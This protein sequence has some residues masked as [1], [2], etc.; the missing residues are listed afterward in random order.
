[1]RFIKWQVV[2]AVTLLL[3]TV[4]ISANNP[5]YI[6]GEV[7]Y[8]QDFAV[9]SDF[10]LSGIQKGTASSELSAFSCR[11]GAFRIETF[12]DGRVYAILPSSNRTTDFTLEFDF[13]FTKTANS[14]GYLAAILTST[15]EEPGNISQVTIRAKGTI[16][17]FE[18]P[19]PELAEHIR[20][21]ET[22]SVK[23][24]VENGVVKTLFLSADGV[25]EEIQRTSLMLIG[26]GNRGFSV[27]NA[28]VDIREVFIVNGTD[29]EN[30]VGYWAE[31]SYADDSASSG[32]VTPTGPDS[33]N[34]ETAPETEDHFPI[35]VL[36]ISA[37][38]FAAVRRLKK[39]KK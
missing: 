31:H 38:S 15:G 16:D 33:N 7:L 39:C 18:A 36:L 28:D 5:V 8:H 9:L 3:L 23:I 35:A 24:P 6:Q 10:S 2:F 1:M 11:D 30:K 20:L 21:G 14:N 34:S 13:S 27:R 26:S 17:D 37:G 25:T 4:P 12:D 22:V 19:S 29:Y 32:T